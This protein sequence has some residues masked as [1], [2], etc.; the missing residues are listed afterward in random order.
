[1]T[2]FRNLPQMQPVLVCR[3]IIKQPSEALCVYHNED[4]TVSLLCEG[5]HDMS[6]GH[7]VTWAHAGH[8]EAKFPH[9]ATLPAVPPGHMGYYFKDIRKWGIERL[10]DDESGN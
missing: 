2:W 10:L 9:T 3:H 1:M 7:D 4:G 8:I 5:D 6:E